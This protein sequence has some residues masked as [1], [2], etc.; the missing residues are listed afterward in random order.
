MIPWPSDMT[1][2]D[3]EVAE[4]RA[5]II[6]DGCNVSQEEAERRTLDLWIKRKERQRAQSQTAVSSSA[7]RPQGS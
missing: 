5:A 2:R 3:R 4:E 6:A 7:D 1:E